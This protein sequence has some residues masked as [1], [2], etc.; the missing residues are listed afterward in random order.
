MDSLNVIKR[1]YSVMAVCL[2]A[3]GAML[4]IKPDISINIICKVTGIVLIGYGI[5]KFA[6]YVTKDLFQLA[7][8]FDL[9][10]GIVSIVFGIALVFKTQHVV[11]ILSINLIGAVPDDE[12]IVISSNQGE[13]LVGSDTQAGQ[14]DMN[15][16][17]IVMR[18]HVPL[19]NLGG[20]DSF[21][22]KLS[23][24]FKKGN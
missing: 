2:I 20:K 8:Q 24:I 9:A 17:K 22:S 3:V 19:L 15:I 5:V 18:E 12:N 1:I 7:F 23:S 13:P 10:L 11:E 4:M 14:A 6:G 16:C 21:W